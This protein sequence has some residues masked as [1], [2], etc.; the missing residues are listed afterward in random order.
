MIGQLLPQERALL[1]NTVLKAKPKLVLEIGTWKGGG[2][3]YQIASA[4]FAI[5]SGVLHTCEIDPEFYTEASQIYNTDPWQNIVFCHHISSTEL[6]QQ[7]IALNTIPDFIFEDGP[8]EPELNMSD[9]LLLEPHLQKSTIFCAHD[10]DLDV[11][12]DGGTSIK[13]KLIR[14]YIENSSKWQIKEYITKP[15]SV[16]MVV[17]ELL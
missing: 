2:S 6:I 13:S 8:E 17:A 4:L 14:P 1:F 16:G 3:T 7:M 15:I 11:R 12:V 5:F 9:F 10:W